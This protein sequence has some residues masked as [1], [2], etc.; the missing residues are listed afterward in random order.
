MT[1]SERIMIRVTPD[2]KDFFQQRADKEGR[3]LT[4]SLFISLKEFAEGNKAGVT[5]VSKI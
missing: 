1:K 4:N 2:M 3:T 5:N